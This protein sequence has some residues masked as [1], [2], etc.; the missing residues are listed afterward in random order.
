MNLVQVDDEFVGRRKGDDCIG[1][2]HGYWPIGN[3]ETNITRKV[4][5]NHNTIFEQ[6]F[7]HRL[8]A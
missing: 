6:C 1:I 7:G 8:Q 5:R 2:L 3:S 4:V